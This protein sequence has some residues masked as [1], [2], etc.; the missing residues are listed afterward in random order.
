MDASRL[1][2]HKSNM[3]KGKTLAGGPIPTYELYGEDDP[4]GSRFWVHCETIPARS[5]LHHW[6]IGLHRHERYFQILL[7]TGGSGDAVFDGEVARFE[8]V[9]VVTVPPGTSVAKAAE[10]LSA[11]RIGAMLDFI[12]VQPD[13]AALI[14]AMARPSSPTASTHGRASSSWTAATTA[15]RTRRLTAWVGRTTTSASCSACS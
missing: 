11:R 2:L 12:E 13:N 1:L 6:E 15:R 8:P 3:M 7:V 4:S 10:I 5:A 9:S 14:A